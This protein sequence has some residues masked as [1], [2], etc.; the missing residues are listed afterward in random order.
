MDKQSS[1]SP[2]TFHILIYG[3]QMNYADSARIKAILTH[4]G[5]QYVSDITQANIVIF[6]TCS[7]R[8]KSEDKVTGKMMEIAPR[9]KVWMTWCMIQH[10]LKNDTIKRSKSHT[11]AKLKY[12]NFLWWVKTTMPQI[13]WWSNTFEEDL[14]NIDDISNT[15]Y[16]NHAYSPLWSTLSQQFDTIELFFRIDDTGFLPLLA[17]KLGYHVTN[18]DI[19]CTNEYANILPHDSNQLLSSS[20]KTAYVPISTGCSQFCSYCIVPYARWLE[21]NRPVDEIL[22]EVSYHLENGIEEIVLLG[23]IVNKHPDF[24]S[25]CEKILTMD[26]LKWLRYTSPYPTFFPPELLQLHK[27]HPKMSPHIHMPLQS[28]SDHILRKMFR[29]YTVDQYKQFVDAIRDT[30]RPISITTDI[31]VWHPDETDED[32]EQSLDMIRYAQFDMIY[33]GIYSPRPGTIGAK[34]YIDN[35]PTKIKKQRWNR[36][37]DLLIS[38]SSSNNQQ[39]IWKIKDVMITRRLKNG[40]LFGYTDNMKN[41]LVRSHLQDDEIIWSLVSVKIVDSKAFTLFGELIV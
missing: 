38:V 22:K 34:R 20:S 17:G 4:A 28:W 5:M 18:T 35:V 39:E 9:Q 14:K 15:I 27:N 11:H 19:E 23:Q 13:V 12:G 30:N 16:V 40:E 26:K 8:Q 1:S 25:L 10:Y 31:I 24:V 41:I 37:N 7:V 29:W 36:M 33:I 6:D 32:F 21:N 3:C 2:T